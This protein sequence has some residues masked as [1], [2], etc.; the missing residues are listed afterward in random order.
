MQVEFVARMP[1]KDTTVF[2]DWN[3]VSRRMEMHHKIPYLGYMESSKKHRTCTQHSE[4]KLNL[5][6]HSRTFLR[7]FSKVA[8]EL[9]EP[10]L[11]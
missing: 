6:V 7:K 2:G 9:L 4:P 10:L 8:A 11:I 1:G 5:S 3:V